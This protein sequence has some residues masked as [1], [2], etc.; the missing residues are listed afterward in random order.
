MEQNRVTLKHF[1]V[2]DTLS[3]RGVA[4]ETM[5][6]IECKLF[7]TCVH[8]VHRMQTITLSISPWVLYW[9]IWAS[10]AVS[11]KATHTHNTNQKFVVDRPSQQHQAL[12]HCVEIL[13]NQAC[14]TCQ[15]WTQ[16][17]VTHKHML[18]WR[19]CVCADG[20]NPWFSYKHRHSARHV[21]DPAKLLGS[22]RC[23]SQIQQQ[24]VGS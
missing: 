24:W 3:N 23:A 20:V 12:W 18:A 6:G 13:M 21:T 14:R 2:C 22:L 11:Y 9:V 7:H 8:T 19:A 4:R 16:L 10:C 5:K 15:H 1:V 17:D